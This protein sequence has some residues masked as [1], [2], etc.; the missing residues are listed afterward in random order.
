MGGAW[1][2]SNR[3]MRLEEGSGKVLEERRVSV[4]RRDERGGFYNL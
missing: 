3:G 2:G 1:S 4:E